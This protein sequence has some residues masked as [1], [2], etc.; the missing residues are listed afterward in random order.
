MQRLSLILGFLILSYTDLG[1]QSGY[2]DVKSVG[3]MKNVKW[4]GE[5]EGSIRLDTIANRSGLYGLGPQDFLK[6]EL[7]IVDGQTFLSQVLSDTSMVVKQLETVEAPFFVYTNVSEWRLYDLGTSVSDIH[8]LEEYLDA[9]TESHKRPFAFKLTGKIDRAQIHIQNLPTGM[10][11]SSPKD[12]HTGQ[13]RY[14]LASE[15]VEIIGFFS[16]LHEPSFYHHT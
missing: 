14:Q 3:A 1:A 4:K 5:L 10:K 12:A 16:A 11:V 9:S 15:E 2:P 8:S 13:V 7:L 6:G